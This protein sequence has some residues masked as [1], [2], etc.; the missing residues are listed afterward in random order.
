MY[1]KQRLQLTVI[2]EY[3]LK[4]QENSFNEILHE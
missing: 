3:Q 1:Q 4:G 2:K